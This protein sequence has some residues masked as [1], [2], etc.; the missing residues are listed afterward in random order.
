M[1]L[2][3]VKTILGEPTEQDGGGGEAL[4]VKVETTTCTTPNP[5]LSTVAAARRIVVRSASC[6]CLPFILASGRHSIL[7]E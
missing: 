1:T 6:S 5:T 4:G 7:I 3:E 2:D